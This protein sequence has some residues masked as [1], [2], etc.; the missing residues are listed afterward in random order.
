MSRSRW[1]NAAAPIIRS[2]LEATRGQ[3]EAAVKKALFD[4]YPF[5]P[6]EHLPYKIWCS[7]IRRQ[8]GIKTPKEKAEQ[9]KAEK[10][11]MLFLDAPAGASPQ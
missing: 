3:P 11:Q 1:R 4:A 8:R 7:E 6:R 5:G 9:A 10:A 2:V